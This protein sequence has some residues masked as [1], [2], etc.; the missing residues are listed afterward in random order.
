M[1]NLPEALAALCVAH[2]LDR[3]DLRIRPNGTGTLDVFGGPGAV[4]Q[5]Q[6]HW[7]LDGD[8]L[9]TP[10]DAVARLAAHLEREKP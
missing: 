7:S 8:V 4:F 10:D 1:T 3:I 6:W 2:A 5:S 9:P